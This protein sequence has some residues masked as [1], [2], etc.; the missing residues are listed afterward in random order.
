VEG[1]KLSLLMDSVVN[2]VH[3][4]LKHQVIANIA[5]QNNVHPNISILVEQGPAV[6]A[7]KTIFLTQQTNHVFL[8]SALTELEGITAMVKERFIREM[9]VN[10]LCAPTLPELKLLTQDVMLIPAET[11]KL[12]S[13]MELVQHAPLIKF[14]AGTEESVLM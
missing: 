4:I 7:R 6:L 3:H 5:C 14:L 12:L 13:V 2:P 11:M 1:I 8:R 10:A 9:V